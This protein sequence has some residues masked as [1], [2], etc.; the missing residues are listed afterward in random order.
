MI[1][2]LKIFM[3]KNY[4]YKMNEFKVCDCEKGKNKFL[5]V[6]TYIYIVI[7]LGYLVQVLGLVSDVYNNIAIVLGI[8]VVFGMYQVVLIQKD[9]VESLI[10]TPEYLINSFGKKT[11]VVV[12]YDQ[13]RKF[14]YTEKTGLLISDR[15][16]EISITPANYKN[17]LG[18]IIEILEAKGK[19][20]DKTREFMKRPI[21]IRIIKGEIVVTD[22]KQEESSTEKLVGEYY[23][24]FKM[25]TP[26]YI[27]DII[28]LNSVI[29]EVFTKDNNLIMKLDKIE[30]KEGH[31]ENTGFDSIIASDCITIFENVKI[32]YVNIKKVRDRN[33]KEEVLPNSLESIIEN[34]EKGVIA[35]WKYRKNGIDLHFAAGTNLVK[36]S[37]E[38]KEVI[39]GWNSFK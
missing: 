7:L 22:I 4:D 24:K 33:A 23:E 5:F 1:E 8:G 10:V 16:N 17:D 27:R 12:N 32:K 39:I 9:K 36:V 34:I 28:F 25:L 35:N 20:F 3:K 38:Y 14:R 31:P 18:P 2:N 19:T 30:V 37:F 29:D 21:K 11:F 13:I 15:K 6:P 26:G